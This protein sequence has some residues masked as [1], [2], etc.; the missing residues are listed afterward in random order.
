[1]NCR[2]TLM[3]FG[4]GAAAAAVVT[5]LTA[6]ASAESQ[7][8]S[9]IRVCVAADGVLRLAGPNAACPSGQSSLTLALAPGSTWSTPSQP[10]ESAAQ[11]KACEWRLNDIEARMK[12][13][14]KAAGDGSLT[15]RVTAP[16]EVVDRA[17]RR[18]FR[19]EPWKATLYNEAGTP[20]A[21]IG[22]AP[23]GGYFSGFSGDQKLVTH[24]TGEGVNV[25]EGD[26]R[27]ISIGKQEAGNY[28]AK[29][30]GKANA[31]VAAIGESTAGS[32]SAWIADPQ[33]N[34]RAGM[35]VDSQQKGNVGV[36]NRSS[37]TV[38]ALTEGLTGGGLLNIYSSSGER[39]VAAGVHKDGFGVVQT[40]PG[41]FS[42]SALL[43]LPGSF[44]AGKR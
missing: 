1:M 37:F 35:I 39:M 43:G 31:A 30:F 4:A 18:I 28:A 6:G 25:V 2:D 29:F 8:D 11:S 34:L 17:G 36:I 22:T 27:R 10:A 15:Q 23:R 16:F 5:C 41:G 38:A 3:G 44:I 13:L 19:V 24:M 12:N 20:V 21:L 14:E 7:G 26:N 32:G 9:T 40:G 33:G 42:S